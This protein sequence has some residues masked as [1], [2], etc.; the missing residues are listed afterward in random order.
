MVKHR[1]VAIVVAPSLRSC[2]SRGSLRYGDRLRLPGILLAD[3]DPDDEE[4]RATPSSS[5]WHCVVDDYPE[6]GAALQLA[7]EHGQVDLEDGEWV[8]G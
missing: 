8:P 5:E 4:T 6:I 3:V 1:A 7:R 2:R